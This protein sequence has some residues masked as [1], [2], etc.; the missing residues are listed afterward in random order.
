MT[1]LQMFI[2][3]SETPDSQWKAVVQIV[4]QKNVNKLASSN[5]MFSYKS[6]PDGLHMNSTRK[7]QAWGMIWPIN[8]AHKIVSLSSLQPACL[9]I[10]FPPFQTG[11]TGILC[12][13]FEGGKWDDD[14]QDFTKIFK[15]RS[16]S[17]P[18]S[19]THQ[20]KRGYMLHS[21]Y[22]SKITAYLKKKSIE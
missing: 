17:Y 22:C 7:C 10:A 1:C 16:E 8:C 21:W 15:G 9:L 4:H 5:G 12:V 14:N 13:L 11:L 3:P 6:C 20:F 19:K 2:T 18:S